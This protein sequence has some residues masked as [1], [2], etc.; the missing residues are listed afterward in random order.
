MKPHEYNLL[1]NQNREAL[2]DTLEHNLDS[3]IDSALSDEQ[4]L[5]ID[6]RN[7]RQNDMITELRKY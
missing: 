4:L 7:Q 5:W 2:R 3:D 6:D 1:L